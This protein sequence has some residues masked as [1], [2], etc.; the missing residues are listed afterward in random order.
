[1]NGVKNMNFDV[2]YR[3][4]LKPVNLNDFFE[5]CKEHNLMVYDLS[6]FMLDESGYLYLSDD[7]GNYVCLPMDEKYIIRVYINGT[8]YDV[9]Y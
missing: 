6:G 4:T 1:M 7:C 2:L 5:L 3:D 9:L 8:V